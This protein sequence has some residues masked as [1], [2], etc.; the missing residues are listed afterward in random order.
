MAQVA[1]VGGGPKDRSFTEIAMEHALSDDE[2]FDEEDLPPADAS[3]HFPA[4]RYAD[5]VKKRLT[6]KLP[7]LSVVE[8]NISGNQADQDEY[9]EDCGPDFGIECSFLVLRDGRKVEA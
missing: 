7:E 2:D 5:D 4:G 1:H 3:D 9:R 6:P 8:P